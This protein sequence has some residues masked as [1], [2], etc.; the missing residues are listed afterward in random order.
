MET[1][2]LSRVQILH[3]HTANYSQRGLNPQEISELNNG[4][5][6]KENEEKDDSNSHIKKEGSLCIRF[7]SNMAHADHTAQQ[8]LMVTSIQRI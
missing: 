6:I 8:F 1:V 7:A 2:F 5:E 3:T 4:N